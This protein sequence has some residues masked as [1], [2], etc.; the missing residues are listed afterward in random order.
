MLLV[1]VFNMR[2]LKMRVKRVCKQCG[3][4]FFV[5]PYKRNTAKYCSKKCTDKSFIKKV[6]MIWSQV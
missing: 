2:R 6:P 4:E 1:G 5:F 3:K